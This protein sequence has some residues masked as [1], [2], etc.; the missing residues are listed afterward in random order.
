MKLE[1]RYSLL[2][3]QLKATAF[4]CTGESPT[5]EL[6]FELLQQASGKTSKATHTFH[7]PKVIAD[8]FMPQVEEF[9][10]TLE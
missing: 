5:N 10:E 9:L 2:I 3:A 7:A 8:E 1:T 6:V 4:F